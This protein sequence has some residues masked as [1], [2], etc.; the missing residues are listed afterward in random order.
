MNLKALSDEALHNSNLKTAKTEREA[1][2]ASLRHLRETERRRL[3]SKYKC[4]SI[5][6]YATKYFGYANDAAD[7]RIKAMRLLQDLPEIEEKIND[8]SLNL[9]NLAL[10]QRLFNLDKKA[11]N[12]YN[13]EQKKEVL[14]KIENQ[15]TRTA[16]KIVYEIKP[17]MKKAK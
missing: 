15:P 14:K 11:G 3:F 9:T 6:D 4:K 2:T 1:I 8:G 5:F 7:R 10:A 12:T 13:K 17:E 16:E